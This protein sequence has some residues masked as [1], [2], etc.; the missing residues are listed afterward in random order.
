MN[1]SKSRNHIT[2]PR[3]VW[4][5]RFCWVGSIGSFIYSKPGT[6]EY[7]QID[8]FALVRGG[9]PIICYFLSLILVFKSELIA[10]RRNGAPEFFLGSFVLYALLSS[11]WSFNPF[12]TLLK[13]INLTFALLCIMR[14]PSL[15]QDFASSARGVFRCTNLFITLGLLEFLIFP[16]LVYYSSSPFEAKRFGIL[17][18]Q[19]GSN[20]LGIV[21]LFSFAGMLTGLTFQSERWRRFKLFY[22]ALLLLMLV[23]AH[24]RL[25]L[26]TVVIAGSYLVLKLVKSISIR[27]LKGVIMRLSLF[28]IFFVIF[29][30]ITLNRNFQEMFQDYFNRG[31]DSR[32]IS[33]LTGRTSVWTEALN[34]GQ[35]RPWFGFG[36]YSG[37]RY[38]LGSES[39]IVRNHSNLD[40]T[41]I[42]VYIDLG[43][44]GVLI[45]FTA[46][47]LALKRIS[48][49]RDIHR[50]IF[51]ALYLVIVSNSLYNPGITTPSSTLLLFGYLVSNSR[52][53][54]FLDE[55]NKI[56]QK[57]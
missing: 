48:T 12:G 11:L 45:L 1:S 56:S 54:K 46:V 25:I 10:P 32:G 23:L 4:S 49:S 19:I 40:N 3:L 28:F 15:Y 36:F 17:V 51:V 13:A 34:F 27:S 14:I 16:E 2:N 57:E 22:A 26:V 37:H 8:T 5:R 43:L 6:S 33:T 21:I 50:G 24:S 38:A 31:Q 29:A 53:L 47:L 41:W 35:E 18:P 55:A 20:L 39:N 44:V 30:L 42:E 9:L 52:R 7:L